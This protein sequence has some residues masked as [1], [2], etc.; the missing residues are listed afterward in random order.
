MRSARAAADA[1]GTD[2]LE[3]SRSLADLIRRRA[4]QYPERIAFVSPAR[5]WTF[6]ELDAQ[7][8]RIAQGFIA[9]GLGA[10]DCVA[11]LTKHAAECI[12]LLLAASKIEAVLAPLNWRLSVRELEYVLGVARP[13]VLMTDAALLGTAGEVRVVD[14]PCRLVTDEP[15]DPALLSTW[16]SRYPALDPGGEPRLDSVT[17]RLFSSGTTGFPKAADLSHRG[18]LT[19]CIEWTG[20][21]RYVQGGTTHLN[22]LPTFH[23]SGIVNAVWMLALAGTAVFQPEFNPQRYLAAIERHRV[24][25]AF[26]VPAM[27]RALVECPEIRTTD[28]STLRCIAYGGA[29]IDEVLLSRCIKELGCGFLQVYG[30][31]EASGTLTA[32]YPEEHD[33]GGPRASLLRSVGKPGA[34]VELRIVSPGDRHDCV[35]G[36]VGEVWVRSAQLMLG[37]HGDAAATAAAF[38]E[39]RDPPGGWLRSG[40]A[41]Y[42]EA[43]YLFL[44]DR[45]KDMIITGGENVYPA[46]VEMTLAAHPAV[47]ES[48]VIGVPDEK[49]G[50]TVKACIV[51]RGGATT[52][53]SE[54]IGFARSRLAHYKCPTS[55]DFLES[56]PRNPSGKILK[57]VL[58]E[59]YW[60]GRTRNIA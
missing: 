13:K 4:A 2:A 44:H 55:V 27:L 3:G 37:Y 48:A 38:P 23:V 46:E 41:G 53:A 11:S 31:T 32:L 40:D 35:E 47:A 43:G 57:R 24:T 52:T 16:A 33:P 45:I 58:R 1:G 59:P 14:I 5:T 10:G 26:A 25:D 51:L 42:L 36:E 8:N 18:I 50:E 21:F 7:S 54:L 6:G 29:P 9:A 60:S 15:D 30:M 22:V 12:L 28:L 49:W 20:P 17:A 39:G 19:H 34:H 56:L